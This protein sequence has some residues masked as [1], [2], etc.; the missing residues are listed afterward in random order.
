MTLADGQEPTSIPVT[1]YFA[2]KGAKLY[3]GV[4]AFTSAN[5]DN[6]PLN[7]PYQIGDVPP[8]PRTY[9]N[10]LNIWGYTGQCVVGSPSNF[11]NGLT[12]DQAA[13]P[14]PGPPPL[15]C[16]PPTGFVLY[17]TFAPPIAPLHYP[18]AARAGW[19][20]LLSAG[21]Q[22]YLSPFPASPVTMTEHSATI[23][24][25]TN[26]FSCLWT[27][28][29]DSFPAQWISQRAWTIKLAFSM[30]VTGSFFG[31]FYVA[32]TKRAATNQNE[33]TVL[34]PITFMGVNRDF[35]G[36]ALAYTLVAQVPDTQF[37]LGDRLV[38]EVGV[39]TPGSIIHPNVFIDAFTV[40]SGSTPI[41]DSDNVNN[42]PLALVS[43][44]EGVPG[45]ADYVGE[46]RAFSGVPLPPNWLACDGSA[47]G[48][49][50]YQ[51]LFQA[52]GTRWGSG[53]L[54]TTFNVPDLRDRCLRGVNPMGLGPDRP[55]IVAIGQV[56]GE[57]Q[58]TLVTG[59]MP[60]HTHSVGPLGTAL[61]IPTGTPSDSTIPGILSTT[62]GSTGGSGA[63][64]NLQPYGVVQFAI[65]AN[66]VTGII[67]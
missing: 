40:D 62:T 22:G 1:W 20:R 49:L 37:F 31:F 42:D 67:P 28:A 27:Y 61:A 19:N 58:H 11:A 54:L 21:H 55:T 36:E 32:L 38:L 50:Q 35:S 47:V 10:G 39:E 33:F 53:D 43:C 13:N 41:V 25:F 64:N 6:S 24:S 17:P 60:A 56:G 29:S 3:K 30:A 51:A 8:S 4:L 2:P 34:V 23:S 66:A 48:R 5:W 63:H 52:I 15:C 45:V 12:P 65:C 44:L 16:K 57:E 9:Y 59:E 26:V 7:G 18:T 14:P 46:I